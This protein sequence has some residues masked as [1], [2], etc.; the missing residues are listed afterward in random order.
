MKNALILSA[1]AITS[2]AGAQ[3]KD[4]GVTDA[5][6]FTE[7]AYTNQVFI[8]GN[9]TTI[10]PYDDQ[11]GTTGFRIRN[12]DVGL[13]GFSFKKGSSEGGGITFTADLVAN[14]NKNLF[15]AGFLTGSEIGV[16]GD[17]DYNFNEFKLQ[18]GR[19]I[20]S[21]GWFTTDAFIGTGYY[22]QH[23]DTD[24]VL[25]DNTIS[26]PISLYA[27]FHFGKSFGMALNPNYSF[28]SVNNNF[29][30]NLLFFFNFN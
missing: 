17:S 19:E 11:D 27:K 21:A 3:Q 9:K 16:V 13:G 20:I 18:Y 23:S 29:S 14:Y 12:I 28:N 1:L 5:G 4:T 25:S 8:P 26:F 24:E 7:S 10:L 22:T 2:Y 15:L 30:A 6:L